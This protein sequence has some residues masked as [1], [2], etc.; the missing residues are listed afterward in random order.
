MIDYLQLMRVPALSDNRTLEIAEIS[1]AESTGERTERAG[2]GAVPVEP[3]SGTTC[4]EC[5]VNS[6]LRE[7]GS[8]EQDADSIDVYLS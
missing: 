8:I 2:G 6:D 1:L 3:F 5:L 4:P 7:S